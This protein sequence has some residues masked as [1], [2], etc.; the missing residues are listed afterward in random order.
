[1]KKQKMLRVVLV[2][3]ICVVIV[4]PPMQVYACGPYFSQTFFKFTMHPDVP[5][6]RFAAGQLG[7]LQTTYARSYL[8]VAYRYLSGEALS[9]EEQA[10]AVSLWK[11]RIGSFEN[12]GRFYSNGETSV[13]QNAWFADRAKLPGIP[14][15]YLPP[16]RRNRGNWNQIEEDGQYD[17]HP[18]CLEPAFERAA[19]TLAKRISQFGA[20]SKEVRSWAE[21]QDAVFALCSGGAPQAYPIPADSSL[22]EII[23]ADRDYQIASAHFYAGDYDGARDLFQQVSRDEKSPLRATGALMVGRSMIRKATLLST[24]SEDE[25]AALSEARAVLEAILKD[26][27]MSEVHHAAKDLISFIDVR[28]RPVEYVHAL[29]QILAHPDG[30]DLKHDLNDYTVLLD[31]GAGLSNATDPGAAG[32]LANRNAKP[33]LTFVSAPAERDMLTDWIYTFETTTPG[34]LAHATDEWRKTHSVAWLVAALANMLPGNSGAD[35][36]LAAAQHVKPDSPG[37]LSVRFHALRIEAQTS[38]KDAARHELD[39]LLQN[40]PGKLPR[41]ARNLF[42]GLRMSLAQNLEELLRDSMRV[43]AGVSDGEYEMEIPGD[44]SLFSS[45]TADTSNAENGSPLFD[46]DAAWAFTR[47]LPTS[48]L[49]RAAESKTLPQELRSAVANSAWVRAIAIGD[50]QNALRLAPIVGELEPKLSAEMKSY[51]AADPATRRF[52]AIVTILRTPGLRLY[53]PYGTPRTRPINEMDSYRDNWWCGLDSGAA[54]IKEMN[55]S[56]A[57][58]NSGQGLTVPSFLSLEERNAVESEWK[59]LVKT[60]MGVTWMTQQVLAWAKAHPDDARVP[61]SLHLAVRASRYA[62]DDEKIRSGVTREAFNLLHRKY[63]NSE[64][65]KKTPYWF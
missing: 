15:V 23:R 6:D 63:P 41:S 43:P 51:V 52:S 5:L 7:V 35:E 53:V 16:S 3:L 24:N 28:I 57:K 29:G 17:S 47:A 1:V 2:V 62:C 37:Y 64:W 65:T 38:Q 46:V 58:F 10:G 8:V 25:N 34:S 59:Q 20:E 36:L 22:P 39:L 40:H 18:N 61:E 12:G 49:L 50:E 26:K 45:G 14:L 30:G 13:S 48:M 11:D 19:G 4:I 32:N 42:L 55:E 44:A 27:S 60:E 21:A 33:I 56:W 54:R 31:N 9:A